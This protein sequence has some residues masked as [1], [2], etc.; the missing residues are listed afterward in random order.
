VAP[1]LPD[2][3]G[4]FDVTHLLYGD[5]LSYELA[6]EKEL[7]WVEELMDICLRTGVRSTGSRWTSSTPAGPR[8]FLSALKTGRARIT[9]IAKTER[10]PFAPGQTKSRSRCAR[11]TGASESAAKCSTPG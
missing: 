5:A 3:Q 6:D 8:T 1:Y 9:G 4:I 7:G 11:S 10:L 2:T